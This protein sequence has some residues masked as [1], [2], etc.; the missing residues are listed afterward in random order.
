MKT[1][2]LA[3]CSVLVIFTSH[4]QAQSTSTT[5]LPPHSLSND[6]QWTVNMTLSE[7]NKISFVAHGKYAAMYGSILAQNAIQA[8]NDQEMRR[9]AHEV[10]TTN[11]NNA[12]QVRL[13]EI[14]SRP[15]LG[16]QCG[17]RTCGCGHSVP[18]YRTWSTYRRTWWYRSRC[19]R[20]GR[21]NYSYYGHAPGI[22][23]R[24]GYRY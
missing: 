23:W 21:V 5:P 2:T 8:N 10:T 6:Q 20:T 12:T 14:A 1:T 24:H 3:V 4:V 15:I 22:I 11:L 17:T 18:V 19:Y 7:G 16:I 9:Q 13:A